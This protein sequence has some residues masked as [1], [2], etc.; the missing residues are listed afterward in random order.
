MSQPVAIILLMISLI[1]SKPGCYAQDV[2]DSEKDLIVHEIDSVFMILVEAA[3]RLDVDMLSAAVDDYYHAGFIAGDT[4]YSDFSKLMD[5]FQTRSQGVAGQKIVLHQKKITVLTHDLAILT[6]NGEAFAYLYTGKSVTTGFLWSF[7]FAR[8][9]N[10]WK[11]IQ[12]H[13]GTT[14]KKP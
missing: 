9:G 8:I 11:V 2:S 5:D 12:S 13:Q 14:R 4:Y 6:A 3:E 7:T 10:A 1:I